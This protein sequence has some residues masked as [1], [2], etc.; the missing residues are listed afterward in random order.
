MKNKI[1][2]FMTALLLLSIAKTAFA[3]QGES[4]NQDVVVTSGAGVIGEDNPQVQQQV[5]EEQQTQNQDEDTQIMIQ[6]NQQI[7]AQTKSQLSEMIQQKQQSMNQELEQK[8]EKEQK[9]YQNQNQVRLA[10]HSLL[11]MED[12]VGGIGKNVS[13]IARQF[14]NSVQ[15]TIRAEEKIQTKS[16]FA[17]FFSGGDSESAEEIE[18][19][20][21]QNKQRI[22]ELKQ[23]HEQCDCDEDVKAMMQEQI[24]KMENEQNRLQEL[25]QKEKKSKGLFGWLWK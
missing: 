6:Q 7:R 12:L 5:N 1:V 16:A 2:F 21:M 18:E 9:V 10:V 19:Q 22:Q 25:A 23:L 17:R 4:G 11:A 3:A 8:S 13:Q 15:A 24:Q 14:N 20:V